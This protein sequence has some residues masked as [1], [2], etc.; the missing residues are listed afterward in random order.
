M[1]KIGKTIEKYIVYN[2]TKDLD[3]LSN[4]LIETI[5]KISEKDKFSKKENKDRCKKIANLPEI[6][7]KERAHSCYID[8]IE[9]IQLIIAN[10]NKIDNKPSLQ[11]FLDCKAWQEKKDEKKIKFIKNLINTTARENEIKLLR[12]Q[13]E[14]SSCKEA[15]RPEI[16]NLKKFARN[17]AINS[18]KVTGSL[19]NMLAGK[20]YLSMNEISKSCRAALSKDAYDLLCEFKDY[21]IAC[22]AIYCASCDSYTDTSERWDRYN[23]KDVVGWIKNNLSIKISCDEILANIKTIKADIK[24]ELGEV[25]IPVTEFKKKDFK[26]VKE[27]L[28]FIEEQIKQK[29]MKRS[30]IPLFKKYADQDIAC[31]VL[32]C[33]SCYSYT[34]STA[35]WNKDNANDAIKWVRDKLEQKINKDQ[36]YDSINKIKDKLKPYLIIPYSLTSIDSQREHDDEGTKN[37]DYSID[38]KQA[39]EF[40]QFHYSGRSTLKIEI[41]DLKK[42]FFWKPDDPPVWEKEIEDKA[43]TPKKPVCIGYFYSWLRRCSGAIQKTIAQELIVHDA[44]IMRWLPH[45]ALLPPFII[46]MK[47]NEINSVYFNCQSREALCLLSKGIRAKSDYNKNTAPVILGK[48]EILWGIYLLSMD[49]DTIAQKEMGA[50]V[51][52]SHIQGNELF[53]FEIKSFGQIAKIEGL[54]IE[55]VKTIKYKT[56]KKAEEKIDGIDALKK[57]R[58]LYITKVK[59]DCNE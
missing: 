30:I 37:T 29:K 27:M 10:Y 9:K 56:T 34:D 7:F 51:G 54:G 21:Q 14:Y 35:K 15:R 18:T 36:V 6:D 8:I 42:T 46:M 59:K 11:I 1:N 39:D 12:K 48:K 31:W 40:Y 52:I 58:Y 16:V 57:E 5:Y 20:K 23:A 32:Y 26:N 28:D 22:W 43:G 13:F 25:K 19:R 49:H 4:L 55:D 41:S 24:T 50:D 44:T 17:T 53:D 2:R 45:A 33:S 38:Q 3:E 47:S